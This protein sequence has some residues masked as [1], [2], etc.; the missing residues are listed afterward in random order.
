M[1]SS[2]EVGEKKKMFK[3]W[4]IFESIVYMMLHSFFFIVFRSIFHVTALIGSVPLVYGTQKHTVSQFHENK[5]RA[6]FIEA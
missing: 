3:P 5:S 6:S 1:T 2:V 4:L